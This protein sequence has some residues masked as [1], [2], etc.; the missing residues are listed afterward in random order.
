MLLYCY[1]NC[2]VTFMAIEVFLKTPDYSSEHVRIEIKPWRLPFPWSVY[3]FPLYF[4]L[5]H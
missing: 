5:L 3:R 1:S 2:R 4:C